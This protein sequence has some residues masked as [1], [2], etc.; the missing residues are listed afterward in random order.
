M[1]T[2]KHF[3]CNCSSWRTG[4]SA[5]QI[6]DVRAAY[7]RL[8]P[9]CT[10]TLTSGNIHASKDWAWSAFSNYTQ[11]NVPLSPPHTIR[12]T[13]NLIIFSPEPRGKGSWFLRWCRDRKRKQWRIDKRLSVTRC[14]APHCC[15]ASNVS[16]CLLHS[17]IHKDWSAAAAAAPEDEE[18]WR[19]EEGEKGR[20]RIIGDGGKDKLSELE[21]E[22]EKKQKKTEE[23]GRVSKKDKRSRHR[24]KLFTGARFASKALQ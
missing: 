9:T 14:A 13:G 23:W 3:A 21:P 6:P 17:H 10:H 24:V 7:S 8:Q 5:A 4:R 12:S 18:G 20:E 19:K 1:H 15:D 22:R 11:R 2:R 16:Q